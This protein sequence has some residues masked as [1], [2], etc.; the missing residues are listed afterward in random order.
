MDEG[1]FVPLGGAAGATGLKKS[2]SKLCTQEEKMGIVS[3]LNSPSILF[4]LSLRK[5]CNRNWWDVPN[6]FAPSLMQRGRR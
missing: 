6:C 4:A 1:A 2:S 5:M 3:Y